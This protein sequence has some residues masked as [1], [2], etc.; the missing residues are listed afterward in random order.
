MYK[1]IE[2]PAVNVVSIRGTLMDYAMKDGVTKGNRAYR[3]VNTS[4]RVK[5]FYNGKEEI[6]EIPVDMIANKVKKDGT[7]NRV[8]EGYAENSRNF[9]PATRVGADK[10]TIVSCSGNRNARLKENI[11]VPK[12]TSEEVHS[13]WQVSSTFMNQAFGTSDSE[14]DYAT[15]DVELFIFNMDREINSIGEETGRL[16]I[17][18]GIVQ[19]GR[20]IDVLPFYVEDASA[21]DYI[22]R[23]YEINDTARFVGRL[24]YT[25]ETTTYVSENTW[26]ESIPTTSSKKKRELII[27]GP[28][29]GCENGPYEE[30]QAYDPAE[31]RVLMADRTARCEQA[32]IE[33]RTQAKA[34]TT[35]ETTMQTTYSWE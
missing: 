35:A 24:R 2:T 22:E 20:K 15:F 12:G 23:N 8:Y 10:A 25:S 7:S 3:R 19:Y 5:Q 31:I 18:G 28:G 1:N 4:V 27:T 16:V 6:S 30:E 33:A 32:K 13:N 9:E 21:I 14:T 11:Y 26:G 34:K 17:R 29:V